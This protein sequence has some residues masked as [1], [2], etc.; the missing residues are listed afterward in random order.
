MF[1]LIQT[2]HG[3]LRVSLNSRQR[4]QEVGAGRGRT[5]LPRAV[6]HLRGLS[7]RGTQLSMR[8]P[9]TRPVVP[10]LL[11]PLLPASSVSGWGTGG[12][13]QI[14]DGSFLKRALQ[15]GVA[16]RTPPSL[17]L[18]G[19]M[20][21]LPQDCP[22]IG[23][24]ANPLCLPSLACSLPSPIHLGPLGLSVCVWRWGGLGG[25]FCVFIQFT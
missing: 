23:L 3:I 17:H 12:S 21:R 13:H 20:L 1:D 10:L 18:H 4:E 6:S 16:T 15:R 25:G 8:H 11:P 7:M 2:S 14:K 5:P 9:V 24:A 22:W 19:R